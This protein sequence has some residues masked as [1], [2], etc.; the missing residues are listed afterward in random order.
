MYKSLEMQRSAMDM[1]MMDP[2]YPCVYL[3][4]DQMPELANLDVDQ[5]AEIT[6]KVRVKEKSQRLDGP[7][8]A[9][10][11]LLEYEPEPADTESSTDAP[12]SLS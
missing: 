3:S 1:P 4:A 6:F 7:L 9:T 12:R 11:E 5:T 8:N 10:L 2:C